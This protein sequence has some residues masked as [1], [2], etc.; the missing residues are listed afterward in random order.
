MKHSEKYP[1]QKE[2]L[3]QVKKIGE[4]LKV[5]EFIAKKIYYGYIVKET[6]KPKIFTLLTGENLENIKL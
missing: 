1:Q 6:D 2:L 3:K 4:S 5:P